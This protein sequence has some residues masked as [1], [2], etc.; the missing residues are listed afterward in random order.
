MKRVERSA[1]VGYSAE[2]MYDLV[3]DIEQYP[4]YMPGCSGA[5]ILERGDTWIEARLDLSKAGLKQSFVTR[6]EL[7]APS[8]INLSLKEG[9]FKALKGQWRFEVLSDTA[10]KISFWLAFEFSNR[11]VGLAADKL[12]EKVA[13]EQVA[14]V[15]A[16]AKQL[17]S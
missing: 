1:L 5:E 10:C 13:S 7:I 2:Q 14:A 4:S 17:Y 8:E 11:L 6:N 12:F 3:N 9:P 16:R 15:T